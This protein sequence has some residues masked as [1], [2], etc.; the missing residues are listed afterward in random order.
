MP[1]VINLNDTTPAAP[2]NHQNLPW[3]ADAVNPDPTVS[4]NV[5]VSVPVMDSTHGG[6]VPTP[7]NDGTK[8][9]AGD[10]TYKTPPSSGGVAF[11]S[12]QIRRTFWAYFQGDPFGLGNYAGPQMPGD[13]IQTT[14]STIGASSVVNSAHGVGSTVTTNSTG[15]AG[16]MY[17]DLIYPVGK[18]LKI[19]GKIWLTR[20]TD[21]RFLFG[22]AG[23]QNGDDF[24][25]GFDNYALFRFSS[26][27]GDT[28]WQTMTN[29]ASTSAGVVN[30]SGVAA[31]TNEHS[32]AIIFD[33]VTPNVKFYL[34]GVLVATH[35]NQLPTAAT[36]LG[37]L[38]AI[39]GNSTNNAIGVG[40]IVID[41][42]F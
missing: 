23:G 8:F 42:D 33:D 35:T 3:K 24:D 31:N 40:Q 30:N 1:Q 11:Q 5:S 12:E 36:P 38:V 14:N 13:T 15:A 21:I 7:P 6:I 39:R 16:F 17:G 37:Y 32:F 25:H 34:D 20:T 28:N 18:S 4:R 2:A 29:D 26:I 10:A 27:A 22:L 19:R 9:L 41:S